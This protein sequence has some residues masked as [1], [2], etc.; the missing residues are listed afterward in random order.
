MGDALWALGRIDCPTTTIVLAQ[1]IFIDAREVLG[2]KGQRTGTA[3]DPACPQVASR[4][5]GI[6]P[7]R[8]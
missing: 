1:P 7:L 8:K 4:L 6:G 5:M 3:L 2:H